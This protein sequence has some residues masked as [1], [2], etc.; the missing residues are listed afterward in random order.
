MWWRL[1]LQLLWIVNSPHWRHSRWRS[2]DSQRRSLADQG[3]A[4]RY[5]MHWPGSQS[6]LR[7]CHWLQPESQGPWKRFLKKGCLNQVQLRLF[8]LHWLSLQ[9]P[10]YWSH[11]RWPCNPKL[12]SGIPTRWLAVQVPSLKCRWRLL[13]NQALLKNFLELSPGIQSPSLLFLRHWM[14]IPVQ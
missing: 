12:S 13:D 1:E 4:Q 2:L 9:R 6:L 11:L 7:S 5:W 3:P 10:N 8:P 14:L